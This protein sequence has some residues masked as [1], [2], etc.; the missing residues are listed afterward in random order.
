MESLT[1]ENASRASKVVSK[2]HPEWGI[3]RFNYN[4]QK[5]RDGSFISTFGIG[6]NVG[7]IFEREY[8]FWNVVSWK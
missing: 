1:K 3:K 6:S 7:L 4:D 8:K 5:L 2:D